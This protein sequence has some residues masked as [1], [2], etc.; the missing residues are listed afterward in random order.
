MG[1]LIW[2]S[3]CRT[4]GALG[5]SGVAKFHHC[6][7]CAACLLGC[8]AFQ[9]YRSGVPRLFDAAVRQASAPEMREPQ[10][11]NGAG[12]SN[13]D[14]PLAL[15]TDQARRLRSARKASRLDSDSKKK[16]VPSTLALTASFGSTNVPVCG[17]LSRRPGRA[18][19]EEPPPSGPSAGLVADPAIFRAMKRVISRIRLRTSARPITPSTNNRRFRIATETPLPFRHGTA[20]RHRAEIPCVSCRAPRPGR[21]DYFLLLLRLLGCSKVVSSVPL[22]LC[23]IAWA[24]AAYGP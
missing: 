16:V 4:A 19:F 20:L 2:G 24:L 18:F 23:T 3:V 8:G 10:G 12:A 7:R 13:D 11:K 6:T 14:G 22:K 9:R 21:P 1:L 5:P 15:A 17:S